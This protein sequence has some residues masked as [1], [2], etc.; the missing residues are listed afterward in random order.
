MVKNTKSLILLTA[1]IL[2]LGAGVS[3]AFVT[4][5]T[6]DPD[7]PSEPV[8]L[9]FIHH[10]V[11]ENWLTDDDGGLGRTLDESNYYVSDT[12]YGWGPDGIGDSTDYYNW[13]DWFLGPESSRILDALYN[14]NEQNSYYTRSLSDPGGENEIIMFKSCYPNSD[15]EGSPDETPS[16]GDWYTVGHA[17]YVYNQIL[18][19]FATRPDKLFV[20][21]TPP[22]LLDPTNAENSKQFSRWLVEDWLE[23]N[24]YPYANVVVWDLHNVLTDPD[25]HHRFHGGEVE[26]TIDNGPATLY[27][28]SDGDEHPNSDGNQK[29]TDEFVPVLN[30]FYNRWKAEA[31]EPEPETDLRGSI[32]IQ[33]LDEDDEALDG[34]TV[35]STLQPTGQPSLDGETSSDGTLTFDD[36]S[37]GNYVFRASLDGYY[38]AQLSGRVEPEETMELTFNMAEEVEE[39]YDSGQRG[40][41]GFPSLSVMIGILAGGIIIGLQRTIVKSSFTTNGDFQ[42]ALEK[43]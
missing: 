27:Y 13:V 35:H 36:V 14:E 38:S 26:Y 37:E 8:R 25:N 10:S 33:V 12:N 24:G 32:Q 15:L 23:E 28:D 29:A 31:S 18:D 34:V 5:Q 11:G 16:D 6:E 3:T 17:K 22:P 20:V 2:V 30:V 4:A 9:I 42:S 19:Y 7:P 39:E 21:I 1:L 40:I 41:P 43:K